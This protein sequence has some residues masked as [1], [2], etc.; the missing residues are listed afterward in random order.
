MK[1]EKRQCVIDYASLLPDT[2]N[3]NRPLST[4]ANLEEICRRA[5]IE[6]RWNEDAETVEIRVREKD[7]SSDISAW[8]WL[9]SECGSFGFATGRRLRPLV[10]VLALRNPYV[11][12]VPER[13]WNPDDPLGSVL[14]S[15]LDWSAP[16]RSWRWLSAQELLWSLWQS[17]ATHSQLT[18]AGKLIM[19]FNGYR[20][21]RTPS[22]RLLLVPPLRS[23]QP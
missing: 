11:P 12:T 17:P 10:R 23:E 16:R 13:G 19:R 7:F 4:V 21:R 6:V 3:G 1:H 20:A 2:R 15:E 5:D 18:K 22:K 14:R 9:I 8:G